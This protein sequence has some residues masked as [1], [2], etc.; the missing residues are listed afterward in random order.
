MRSIILQPLYSSKKIQER[1][2]CV[3][4]LMRN[5]PMLL[6]IQVVA[7]ESTKKKPFKLKITCN[8]RAFCRSC[9]ILTWFYHWAL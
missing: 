6:S 5:V 3:E 9:P 1:L 2:D 4:E 7:L 8:N